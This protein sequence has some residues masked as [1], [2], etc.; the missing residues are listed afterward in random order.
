MYEDSWYGFVTDTAAK[1]PTIS[2]QPQDH[3]PKESLLQQPHVRCPPPPEITSSPRTKGTG[4]AGKAPE[5]I[6]SVFE[7]LK[8]TKTPPEPTLTRRAASYS[9]F[10]RVVKAQ[11]AKDRQGPKTKAGSKDRRCEALLLHGTCLANMEN[12]HSPSTCDHVAGHQLLRASQQDYL[13]VYCT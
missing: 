8:D 11:L 1:K 5:P 10:Y 13:C 4:K 2:G 9:D 6:S 3:R 12:S 7:E